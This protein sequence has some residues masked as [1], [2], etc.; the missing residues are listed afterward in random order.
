MQVAPEVPVIMAGML[1]S[2]SG[3]QEVP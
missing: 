1:G 3:W 2:T